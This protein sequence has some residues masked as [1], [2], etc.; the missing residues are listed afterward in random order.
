MVEVSNK[1]TE[2]K[3]SR[4]GKREKRRFKPIKL[5][6]REDPDRRCGMF[7]GFYN[8]SV[9]LT[10]IGLASSVYGITQVF[11][12]RYA[13][14][15]ICLLIS[16]ICDMFDGKIA[17]AMKNRTADEKVFGIQ[18]DS[19]CD[20]V[21]FGVYPAIIGYS[22]GVNKGLGIISAYLIVQAAVIR[23]GYFNVTEEERQQI[24]SE[25]RKKYQGLPVTTVAMFFPLLYLGRQNIPPFAFPYV[26]Q[27]MMIVIALLFILNINVKK[28][29]VK[30]IVLFFLMGVLIVFG[31]LK[32]RG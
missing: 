11:E 29:S 10:Y 15:Y 8:P 23:L 25:P 21:C 22:Y 31:Y 9:I 12:R 4:T 26:I 2:R 19:L 18:I 20:L 28:F 14:V 30:T 17:R 27:I 6:R 24:C 1:K 3:N 7:I 16:G 5:R 32:V 13:V